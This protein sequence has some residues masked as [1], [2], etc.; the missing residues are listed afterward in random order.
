MS[1]LSWWQR[2]FGGP[3]QHT[4]YPGGLTPPAFFNCGVKTSAE[5]HDAILEN[6]GQR[7]WLLGDLKFQVTTRE[8]YENYIRW[9]HREH[10]WM[11]YSLVR[12]CD[13]FA[14]AYFGDLNKWE[15][16]CATPKAMIWSPYLGGHAYNLA[17]CYD[18]L[19][20][21]KIRVYLVEPQPPWGEYILEEL[22]PEH[23][24]DMPWGP[25]LFVVNGKIAQEVRP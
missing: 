18:D 5:I 14:A 15:G 9:W 23:F 10:R 12:D 21:A 4:Y 11:T 6:T 13:N 25:W 24:E 7:V 8:A 2:L 20:S 19:M 17:I 3:G 16:W 1:I 22:A